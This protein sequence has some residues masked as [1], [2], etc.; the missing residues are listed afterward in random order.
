MAEAA[1]GDEAGRLR[2]PPRRPPVPATAERF[3]TVYQ[4]A[5]VR[6]AGLA[7]METAE[8]YTRAYTAGAPRH[9]LRRAWHSID[10]C[11][12]PDPGGLVEGA[13]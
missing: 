5:H 6:R 3:A 7:R 2:R 9:R 8:W 12:H 11:A 1:P 4:L 10:S 13:R